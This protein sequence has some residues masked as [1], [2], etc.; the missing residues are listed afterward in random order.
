MTTQSH[1][2]TGRFETANVAS[3]TNAAGA[4]QPCATAASTRTRRSSDKSFD[5]PADLRS[6]TQ[7]ESPSRR[8]KNPR[9]NDFPRSKS[10]LIVAALQIGTV[11][12]LTRAPRPRWG[13]APGPWAAEAQRA[14]T[15]W[16]ERQPSRLCRR[17]RGLR[18][19]GPS[20]KVR[21]QRQPTVLIGCHGGSSVRDPRSRRVL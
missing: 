4:R 5:M 12:F 17:G 8:L 13:S 18:S 11:T 9:S 1:A 16:A 21:I 15:T 20:G 14:F 2:T 7:S 19:R 3:T 6:G 10:A